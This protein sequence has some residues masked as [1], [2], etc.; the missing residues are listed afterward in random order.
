MTFMSFQ[1]V[2]FLVVILIIPTLVMSLCY[3]II[4]IE[5]CRVVKQRHKMTGSRYGHVSST[6]RKKYVVF[7]E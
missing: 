3:G 5:I 6:G 4:I 1:E 7:S 2:Y